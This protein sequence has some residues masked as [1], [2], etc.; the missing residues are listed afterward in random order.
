[1]TTMQ[2]KTK[3][4]DDTVRVGVEFRV[5][6]YGAAC[7]SR[8][9]TNVDMRNFIR[10]GCQHQ[11]TV[12]DGK[13]WDL[14]KVISR[15][16]IELLNSAIEDGWL[17]VSR[18]AVNPNSWK[19]FFRSRRE[20]NLP[21]GLAL[22]RTEK[23]SDWS[24]E[25]YWNACESMKIMNVSERS[26][27]FNEAW[28]R[29]TLRCYSA[30]RGPCVYQVSSKVDLDNK[31]ASIVVSTADK[32][33]ST[34]SAVVV[35]SP[36]ADD[37]KHVVQKDT[38]KDNKKTDQV[39]L[40]VEF[41][42]T[43]L[44]AESY[45]W[46]GGNDSA[47]AR[48]TRAGCDSGKVIEGASWDLHKAAMD[49]YM[50]FDY[51]NDLIRL[52]WIV[53]SRI[54]VNPNSTTVLH[55]RRTSDING[56]MGKLESGCV[57]PQVWS[58]ERFW[59][60][61]NYH[62]NQ[63]ITDAWKLGKIQLIWVDRRVPTISSSLPTAP[64]VKTTTEPNPA[65][66]KESPKTQVDN[67]DSTTKDDM[68]LMVEFQVTKEG[69]SIAA[70]PGDDVV[71]LGCESG[72]QGKGAIWKLDNALRCGLHD[73]NYLN[74]AI[75]AGWLIVSAV[76]TRGICR[77]EN[78]PGF[79][80]DFERTCSED[81]LGSLTPGC[82]RG[83]MEW[84]LGRFWRARSRSLTWHDIHAFNGGWRLGKIKLN[85]VTTIPVL[86]APNVQTALSTHD[87]VVTTPVAV[88][89]DE[90]PVAVIKR[91]DPIVVVKR[92]EQ[93]SSTST[94][95]ASKQDETIEDTKKDDQ[96]RLSVE[97]Q[98]T[99]LGVTG[100][101]TTDPGNQGMRDCIRTGCQDQG[102]IV[103]GTTWS[104]DKVVMKIG[105]GYLN[106]A[107]QDGWL[108]VT[109][110]SV[111]PTAP[112]LLYFRHIDGGCGLARG[113]IGASGWS[114]KRF[115]QTWDTKDECVVDAFREAWKRNHIRLS[116]VGSYG[117]QQ[118]KT[119]SDTSTT[120]PCLSPDATT[121]VVKKHEPPAA[122]MVIFGPQGLNIG[123]ENGQVRLSVEFQ[124]TPR[125]A[126]GVQSTSGTA[127]EDNLRHYIRFG[128]KSMTTSFEGVVWKFEDAIASGM[129]I[130]PLNLAIRD[131][132]LSVSKI[133]MDPTFSTGKFHFHFARGR[134]NQPEV[135]L[136]CMESSNQWSLEKFWIECH[137][138]YQRQ[139]V[140]AAR[141]VHLFNDAWQQM[142]VQPFLDW[143]MP[144]QTRKLNAL[145]LP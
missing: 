43:R 76:W 49:S 44:G 3:D 81:Q 107:I 103:N 6:A 136:G 22:G 39:R 125:G 62:A 108:I 139:V 38:D 91:D 71:R 118:V 35:S 55:F 130:R 17:V 99:S 80:L 4:D 101:S 53:I 106:Q 1:M 61:M 122:D 68:P 95:A 42:V 138:D 140:P 8:S 40:S 70:S 13:P 48:Y 10:T 109:R 75:R 14:D 28:Q 145:R 141:M 126:T 69:A 29:D 86:V 21:L 77:V 64:M 100:M 133:S 131:G 45:C 11:G 63:D 36:S 67:E 16:G 119:D 59:V 47:I 31:T 90:S 84:S 111:D 19:L 27:M 9:D 56:T 30:A 113:K 85:H 37:Q 87:L 73:L 24:L 137:N 12:Y 96:V 121:V 78:L 7:M 114:L 89:K 124:V 20:D 143:T 51:L 25:R 65:S 57:F 110:I 72:K 93:L 54:Y 2:D 66:G 116:A 74:R 50:G 123:K 104:L 98:V 82:S 46:C 142:R 41:R 115:W 112:W 5:T 18:I 129:G 26:S 52:E 134:L 34:S 33:T 102:V 32:E 94:S 58:L 127:D 97:F 120:Q 132:W 144:C 117:V 83:G 23:G 105:V 15:T 92:D 60:N 135:L 79:K 128:C 88:K